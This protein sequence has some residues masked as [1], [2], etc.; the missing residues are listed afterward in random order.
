MVVTVVMVTVVLV[1]VTMM[2]TATTATM[3]NMTMTVTARPI[4]TT[5]IAIWMMTLTPI[6]TATMTIMK[7]KFHL[8]L[9]KKRKYSICAT[10]CQLLN[11]KFLQETVW[12]GYV[13]VIFSN[14]NICYIYHISNLNSTDKKKVYEITP[15]CRGQFS[16][17]TDHN[18]VINASYSCFSRFIIHTLYTFSYETLDNKICFYI[19]YSYVFFY[20]NILPNK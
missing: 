7:V 20:I 12:Y 9:K 13:E 16:A 1:V 3:V 14:R 19:S 2:T 4:S 17:K 11:S 10:L 5:M 18:R 6:L 8:D 15:L